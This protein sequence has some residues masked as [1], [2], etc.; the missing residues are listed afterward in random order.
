MSTRADDNKA[1]VSGT[2]EP[3]GDGQ[4]DRRRHRPSSRQGEDMAQVGFGMTASA[5]ERQGPSGPRHRHRAP[6]TGG[7]GQGRTLR[8]RR[9][10]GSV[11]L[12][13]VGMLLLAACGSTTHPTSSSPA[14]AASAPKVTGAP[15][16]GGI[17]SYSNAIGNDFSWM[18]PLVNGANYEPWDINVESGM[19]RPLYVAGGPGKAGIDY[20]ASIAQKPV[21]SHGN[22]Q[23]TVNLNKGWTWSDGAPVTTS[24]VRF[25]FEL[26]AAGARAGKYAPYVP[27]LMPNDIASVSYPSAYQFVVHLK[28]AYNPSWF[29][30]NQLT[31]VYP[32][33][34]QAWDKTCSACVVGHNASTPAGAAKVFDF[35]YK[36]SESLSTYAT[37][38]IWKV[39]DGPW[40]IRSYNQATYHTVFAA[41]SHYTG[42]GKPH[43]AGYQVYSPTSDTAEL[44]LVRSGQVDFGYIPYSDAGL[45]AHFKASGYNVATW[46]NFY[47]Q[48][49]EFGYTGPWKALVSQLYIRQALQHLVNQQLYIKRAL[50]GYGLP[51]YGPAPD[52]PGSNL[53][54]PALRSNPYPYSVAAAKK[55]LAAH[56][57]TRG[58]GGVDVCER[59]GSASNECGAGIPKGKPLSIMF[60]YST[61]NPS[62]LAQV[63]AFATAAKQAGIALPLN[64]QSTT[65]MFSIAGTC[66]SS[67]CKWGIAGYSNYLW[68][69]G[70]YQTIPAGNDQF[71]KGNY[72]AGGYYSPTAQRLIVAT[73]ETAGLKPLYAA[74]TYLSKNVASLWWPVSD[75]EILV[76]KKNLAGW[77]PLNPYANYDVSHWYLVK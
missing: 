35:L 5:T 68:D 56:G 23:V 64:G 73:H 13:S 54:A 8:A 39:V 32:L 38:P 57:W 17:A 49:M 7:T 9:T 22:T 44:N 16:R 30:G 69:Y 31:W 58:S 77:Y 34:R 11:A 55:L 37:N 18:L 63:E 15:I 61:G 74:E 26:E 72:W 3:A 28:R 59:P 67:P 50:H 40:V 20:S 52:Y 71:G 43:L 65:S 29:T 25:F 60:M 41:N 45:I 21:Y 70:Q 24:D 27:G 12:A 4:G 51:N 66:P 48:D 53:V 14:S 75:F 1:D 76:A 2:T 47:N 33:P 10:L 46:P 19:W 36:Q 6:D 62:F 42:P